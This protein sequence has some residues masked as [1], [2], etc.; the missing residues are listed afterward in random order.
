[1]STLGLK[2]TFLSLKLS[3][4]P[5]FTNTVASIITLQRFWF[6]PCPT[7]GINYHSLGPSA[8]LSAFFLFNQWNF[9]CFSSVLLLHWRMFASEIVEA[10]WIV[11]SVIYQKLF[12]TPGGKPFRTSVDKLKFPSSHNY[13][14][15]LMGKTSELPIVFRA[16]P[17][18]RK[19]WVVM[20]ITNPFMHAE[21]WPDIL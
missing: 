13:V 18:Q 12:K 14:V 3:Q 15:F 9:S 5:E 6:F 19:C 16:L 2:V 20:K 21:K 7:V 1:M 11:K 17:N 10:I 4:L 8:S